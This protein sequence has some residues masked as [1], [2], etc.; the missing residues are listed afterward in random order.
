MT[1]VRANRGARNRPRWHRSRPWTYAPSMHRREA[2]ARRT[3]LSSTRGVAQLSASWNPGSPVSAA[4]AVCRGQRR[5]VGDT[6]QPPRE[7]RAL[8]GLARDGRESG[9]PSRSPPSLRRSSGGHVQSGS[10]DNARCTALPES[11]RRAGR[12]RVEARGRTAEYRKWLI[13]HVWSVMDHPTQSTGKSPA[14]SGSF[15][16]RGVPVSS[17]HHPSRGPLV[18]A[19]ALVLPGPQPAPLSAGSAGITPPCFGGSIGLPPS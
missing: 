7:S 15:G 8:C 13:W 12:V 4:H 18:P 2:C 10:G 5:H 6:L 19:V 1:G 14:S 17:G 16:V 3:W 9:G 11:G